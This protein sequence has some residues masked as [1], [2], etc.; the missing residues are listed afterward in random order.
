MPL[1]VGGDGLIGSALCSYFDSEK[2]D[3]CATSSRPKGAQIRLDLSE[4]PLSWDL[5]ERCSDAFLCA[6]QTDLKACE[7][8]P[9]GT[10]LINVERNVALGR[11]LMEK[12]AFL[13]F[14][15]SNLVFDGTSRSPRPEDPPVPA[16]EYGRQ[17]AR[18]EKELLALGA[19]VAVVRLTKVVHA[20]MPL[21]RKWAAS[22]RREQPIHPYA[23]LTFSPLPLDFVPMAFDRVA[24][25]RL[26]GIT[27]LSGS[28]EITYT[29]FALALARR[30]GVTNRLVQP[31][32]DPGGG[33]GFSTLDT[34]RATHE[35]GLAAPDVFQTVE[36][37]VL[38]LQ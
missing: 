19:D 25:K 16:C 11:I 1:I 32:L 9:E 8:D 5:P 7:Q 31:V 23:D 28:G 26:A 21:L 37:L 34:S 27:Q 12:G 15:S 17:K 20:G 38:E 33:R 30:L 36:T 2:V 3:Y 18:A 22:L 6:A 13:I 4:D 10:A 35:L 24:E 29:E 14:P